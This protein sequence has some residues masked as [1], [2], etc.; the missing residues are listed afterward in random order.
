MAVSVTTITMTE[1]WKGPVVGSDN[2]NSGGLT[3]TPLW[4]VLQE[5]ALLHRSDTVEGPS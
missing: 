3:G 4:A 2:A 5:P 1:V